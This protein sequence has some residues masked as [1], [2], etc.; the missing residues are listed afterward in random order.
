MD[1]FL[2]AEIEGPATR[3]WFELQK[4]FSALLSQVSKN[5]YGENLISIG[6]ISIIMRDEYFKEGGYKE[7]KYYNRGR[8][9][10]DIRLRINY[11]EFLK[12]SDQ[13]RRTIYI[14]HI[15][16]SICIAGEKAGEG[17]ETERLISDV[18]RVLKG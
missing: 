10:A 6:I 2:S 11:K 16:E 13:E 18:K 14:N 1:I 8:R 15:I 3:K 9:E 5:D 4:E 17:F 12:A 7:R